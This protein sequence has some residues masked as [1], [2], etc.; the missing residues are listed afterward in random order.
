MSIRETKEPNA[1]STFNT[2]SLLG[3]ALL[4]QQKYAD[5]EPLLL[6]GYEGMKQRA[7]KIPPQSKPRLADAAARL[8]Q[9]YE[10]TNRPDDAQKWKDELEKLKAAQPAAP[11]TKP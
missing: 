5:A 9:L 2:Q 8:V 4:G 7:D 1:W 6:K 10:A 3:A 11:A